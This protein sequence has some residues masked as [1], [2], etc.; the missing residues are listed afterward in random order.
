MDVLDRSRMRQ[1]LDDNR[2]TTLLRLL[3]R[4]SPLADNAEQVPSLKA[5]AGLYRVEALLILDRY[6][7]AR[8]ILRR[9]LTHLHGDDLALAYCLWAQVDIDSG[10]YDQAILHAEQGIE[11]NIQAQFKSLAH[12]W[13]AI[14]YAYK[15]C[16]GM[17]DEAI[18]RAFGFDSQSPRLLAAQ[19]HLC[20][21]ADQRLEARAIYERL[22]QSEIAW[23][24]AY[25][26]WGLSQVAYLLGEFDEARRQAEAALQLSDE[27]ILP[28]FT[29][30]YLALVVEDLPALE[31]VVANLRLRSPKSTIL[32]FFTSESE[33]LRIFHS[34]E[35]RG[36]RK[37]LLAFPTTMQRRNYC[38]PSTIE[39]ILR[40]WDKVGSFDNDQIAA[41]VK[42]NYGGTPAYRMR[43]FFQLVGFDT[44]RC[45]A[46]AGK[47]IRLI[48]AGFP[49]IIQEEYPNS[50]HVSVAIGYDEVESVLEVQDPMTHRVTRRAFSELARRRRIYNEAALIAFPRGR[51]FEKQLAR[52][53]LHDDPAVVWSDQA[54]LALDESR[55]Q[56][57]A[58]LS[59]QAVHRQPDYPLAWMLWLQAEMESW[60]NALALPIGQPGDGFH[61][62]SEQPESARQRFYALLELA[63][64]AH[65]MAVFVYQ[66][67]GSAAMM[68]GDF[69][70][71]LSELKRAN[72]I[73]P[74][75]ARTAAL[76]AECNY[77][78]RQFKHSL[79]WAEKALSQ[80]PSLASANIWM[81][82]SLVA[83]GRP[84]ARHYASCAVDLSPQ[85]WSARHA[86]AEAWLQEG[87]L[88]LARR[89]NELS[90]SLS[91]GEVEAQLISCRLVALG[92][93]PAEAIDQVQSLLNGEG[94]LSPSTTYQ[95][96]H[97]LCSILL[98][99]H[100]YENS[101]EH[102][103][104]LLEL[105]PNDPWG[106]QAQ[107][108]A[109]A[110]VLIQAEEVSAEA[111]NTLCQMYESALEANQG[112]SSVLRTYLEA[113]ELLSGA[114]VVLEVLLRLRRRYPDHGAMAYLQGLLL[115]QTNR[116]DEAA[117]VMIE[118]LSYV[119]GVLNREELQTAVRIIV[120]GVG[121]V[122]AENL[123]RSTPVPE[124]GASI[125]E[126]TRALGLVLAEKPDQSAAQARKLLQVAL[127]DDPQ[128]SQI[129][130]S[131]GDVAQSEVDRELLYRQALLH[132]PRWPPARARLAR[133]LVEHE[134]AAEAIEFTSGHETESDELLAVHGSA[135]LGLRRY[136][137]A[138]GVYA[139]AVDALA[140]AED[141]LWVEKWSAEQA[142]G[143]Y[144]QAAGSAQ[145]AMTLFPADLR[146]YTRL[147]VSLRSLGELAEAAEVIARGREC[148]LDEV[149]GL[150]V[151]V[152]LAWAAKDADTALE[153]I[154][155]LAELGEETRVDGRL[156]W[157]EGR[158][159][160]LLVELNRPDEALALVEAV[161]LNADGWGEA[162]WVANLYHAPRL[163]LTLAEQALTIAPR[164]YSGLYTRA[165]ALS[166]LGIE[167]EAR[168]AY[169]T[170]LDAYPDEHHAYE[171][172]ALRLAVAGQSAQALEQAD[173]AVALGS[174]CPFAWAVRGY[175]YSLNRQF[176]A[177]EADLQSGWERT[178]ARQRS[179]SLYYWWLLAA[180]RREDER[181]A[182]LRHRAYQQI[183]TAFDA[184][185]LAQVEQILGVPYG[186]GL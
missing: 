60:R 132:S 81:A 31:Q 91:T 101:L 167:A 2:P 86:L 158:L 112:A 143:W 5:I 62:Q 126:R 49:V 124:G 47:I 89:E 166:A 20:L 178:D 80:E 115:S 90:I 152:E 136:E 59:E 70:Q 38:G 169:Q 57:A 75:N 107:A 10:N 12:A 159:F 154:E 40:Y 180:L 157:A 93:N 121:S 25:G 171:K 134:R 146:W 95:A 165:E 133:Y 150:R 176:S 109:T 77:E 144:Q 42:D 36:R 88:Q 105:F 54:V 22:C 175:V 181:A 125:V 3:S 120:E 9:I 94:R 123:L 177:A 100:Q 147:A 122:K 37:R 108:E 34:S 72:H 183:A 99:A 45:L 51:G 52:L 14:G 163:A 142:C 138:A 15:R 21:E 96:L 69:T 63:R 113:V 184:R 85:E 29:L 44:L 153:L 116:Q 119:D 76:L 168:R 23:G 79:D 4:R 8:H 30:G 104:R 7:E 160:R 84:H 148:G 18:H 164:Q 155:R 111:I 172:L 117:Q 185:I 128:D 19:A 162:A 173:R 67:S 64:Q 27:I 145:S 141:W 24:R 129:M 182:E 130:L 114:E 170:L 156:S 78:L 179:E 56:A 17:A 103:T 186:L 110:G 73:D 118:T 43:E 35:F 92:G 98:E 28:F 26:L 137:E 106:L 41:R 97:I 6:P 55:L 151:E 82:R 65:P 174:F 46:P 149:D 68:D 127:T 87:Q 74:D 135:L 66:Y 16:W 139:Q 50:S 11:S 71:A 13:M 32:S 102:L 83:L 48:D 53:G 61:A 131:L 33:T 140:D 161:H 1:L 39:L 58:G